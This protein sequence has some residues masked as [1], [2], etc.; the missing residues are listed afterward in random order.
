MVARESPIAA[1]ETD[2]REKGAMEILRVSE[3]WDF[4]VL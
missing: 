1:R 3:V 2:L 4:W